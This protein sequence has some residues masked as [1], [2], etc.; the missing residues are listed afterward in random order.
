MSLGIKHLARQLPG[1]VWHPTCIRKGR[2]QQG[3]RSLEFETLGVR[4]VSV[5]RQSG[6]RVASESVVLGDAIKN[7]GTRPFRR[8][9]AQPPNA[10]QLGGSLL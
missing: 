7:H 2:R 8:A 1:P 3:F 9:G 6:C 5:C 10:P 4:C